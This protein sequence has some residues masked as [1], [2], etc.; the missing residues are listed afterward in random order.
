MVFSADGKRLIAADQIF[1]KAG[2]LPSRP[3]CVFTTSFRAI[4]WHAWDL[5]APCWAIAL[6]PEGGHVAAA[7]Q[8]SVALILRLPD[9]PVR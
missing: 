8:D 1:D 6:A 7:Q 3:A 4:G 9:G 5:S 2:R